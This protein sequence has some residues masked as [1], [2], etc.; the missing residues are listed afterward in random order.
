MPGRTINET[1]FTSETRFRFDDPWEEQVLLGSWTYE[2]VAPN[3]GK[4]ILTY[5]IH[6][7][8]PSVYREEFLWSFATETSG[9]YDYKDY[10][11][12][13]LNWSEDGLFDFPWLLE[14]PTTWYHNSVELGDGWHWLG[15][16]KGFKPV[17][18]SWIYHSRHAWLFVID[19]DPG[20]LFFWDMSLGSWFYT[21]DQIY[22]WLY[23]FGPNSGWLWFFED[24]SPGER[25]FARGDTGE[26]VSED[27]LRAPYNSIPVAEA[28]SNLSVVDSDVNGSETVRLDGSGS[29]DPDGGIVNYAWSWPG[30]GANG[31]IVDATLPVGTTTVTLTVTDDEGATDTDSLT[32][33]V[34]PRG[35]STGDS[36]FLV[37]TWVSIS[38]G[39]NQGDMFYDGVEFNKSTFTVYDEE[40]R[41]G[42]NEGPY[43][44]SNGL[45]E[46]GG[47]SVT[48]TIINENEVI[49]R[50]DT[51]LRQS[52][53]IGKEDYY[54]TW[55]FEYNESE[56][57]GELTVTGTASGLT[58]SL[59][60]FSESG[61][62]Q[63]EYSLQGN[64]EYG[65][66][67]LSGSG[68]TQY[69]Q[70]QMDFFAILVQGQIYGEVHREPNGDDNSFT[71]EVAP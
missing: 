24:G 50:G 17:G 57:P 49:I 15:W 14:G 16:F 13:V 31:Q 44:Y 20:S 25:L 12:D 37:G 11:N 10:I 4:L 47:N 60:E 35:G 51:M 22:P 7:D 45:L 70:S 32:V 9:A 56:W 41:P 18:D 62:L 19:D 69:G 54:G 8:D 30:G 68:T 43:S 61:T 39:S 42:V 34:S 28:G 63:A 52:P 66:I 1:T 23:F 33:Q 36:D 71:G 59:R 48:L 6:E 46:F 38:E 5:D 67:F 64:F 58:A 3:V 2:R 40:T 21:N 29:S 27:Q 26:F 53:F 55:N 65:S